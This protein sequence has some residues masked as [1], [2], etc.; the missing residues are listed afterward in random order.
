MKVYALMMFYPYEGSDLL[1]IF[2]SM[3][4]AEDYMNSPAFDDEDRQFIEIFETELGV[5]TKAF[6]A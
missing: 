2:A 6:C 5:P 4:D 1:G 3:Q